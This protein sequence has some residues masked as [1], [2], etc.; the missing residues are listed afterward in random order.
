M[1]SAPCNLLVLTLSRP[2]SC[3]FQSS[4]T[5][6]TSQQVA[7]RSSGAWSDEQ[8]GHLDLPGSDAWAAREVA[9]HSYSLRAMLTW[10]D[11]FQR[12]IL[13]QAGTH[14]TNHLTLAQSQFRAA[15][16]L[17]ALPYCRRIPLQYA[18]RIP[19]RTAGPNG[20]CVSLYLQC[21]TRCLQGCMSY[22]SDYV[23]VAGPSCM[24][25]AP[26]IRHHARTL[27]DCTLRT[28]GDPTVSLGRTVRDAKPRPC[29]YGP[30]SFCSRLR[31]VAFHSSLLMTSA[32]FSPVALMLRPGFRR[33]HRRWCRYAG[34][35]RHS[36]GNLRCRPGLS[37]FAQFLPKRLGAVDAALFEQVHPPDAGCGL[38]K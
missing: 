27:A 3:N 4:S 20:P 22:F 23:A 10:D 16:M 6:T 29:L 30:L 38:S 12:R 1:S 7:Q 26:A 9:W 13:N 32:C 37:R 25:L 36:V 31:C 18:L 24:C 11:F 34:C 28:Q 21:K 8:I 2:L 14:A 5:F 17:N 15:A 35:M 19:G 33:A